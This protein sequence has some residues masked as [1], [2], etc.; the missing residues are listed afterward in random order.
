[1]KSERLNQLLMLDR[2]VD[3][4]WRINM[5]ANGGLGAVEDPRPIVFLHVFYTAA[6]SETHEGILRAG[7][8]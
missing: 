7:R 3:F 6:V 2:F 4:V 1:M 5:F 8:D